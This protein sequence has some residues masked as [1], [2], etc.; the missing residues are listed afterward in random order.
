MANFDELIARLHADHPGKENNSARG[1]AFEPI[2]K[3]FLTEDPYYGQEFRN[4]WLW[5]EWPGR[6]SGDPICSEGVLQ[7]SS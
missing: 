6:P 3:W 5:D 7:P 4:V 1:K 2:C